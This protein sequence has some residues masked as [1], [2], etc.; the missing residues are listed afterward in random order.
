MPAKHGLWFHEQ[1]R[2][3]P[4]FRDGGEADHDR[5]LVPMEHGFLDVAPNDDELLA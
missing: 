3:L 4:A 1:D 2:V 5:S